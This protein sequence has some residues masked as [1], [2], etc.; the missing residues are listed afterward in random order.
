[1]LRVMRASVEAAK[2]VNGVPA[3]LSLADLIYLSAQA[4]NAIAR[5]SLAHLR[6][7]PDS[8]YSDRS[9]PG[10][11]RTFDPLSKNIWRSQNPAIC[12]SN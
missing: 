11:V 9:A 2:F 5:I 3:P 7:K 6:G 10:N 12:R 8:A 1:M 4:L